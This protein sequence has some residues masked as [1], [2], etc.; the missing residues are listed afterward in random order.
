MAY[1]SSPKTGGVSSEIP[2]ARFTHQLDRE[3][4]AL[5]V[6]ADGLE[7]VVGD[8]IANCPS[9]A[10]NASRG[11]QTI[12]FLRQ[13]LEALSQVMEDLTAEIPDTV[14]VDAEKVAAKVLL[15]D[16]AARLATASGDASV[17]ITDEPTDDGECAFF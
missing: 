2:L 12:D 5:A 1:S 6:A 8:I 13:S 3:L 15:R 14:Y 16:L 7:Q 9:E 11:L 17:R 4:D 10:R